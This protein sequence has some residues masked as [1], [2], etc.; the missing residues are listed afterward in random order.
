MPRFS[1]SFSTAAFAPWPTATMAMR[2]ATPMNTPS[3]VRTARS[4]LRVMAW[5]AAASTISA[6]AHDAP[7]WSGAPRAALGRA[8]RPAGGAGRRAAATPSCRTGSSET[9]R[10]SRMVTMRSV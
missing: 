9:M 10:P 3:M 4:L 1:I 8:R 6:N 5:A 2:A 7:R